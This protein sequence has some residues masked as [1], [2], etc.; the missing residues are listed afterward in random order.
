MHLLTVPRQDVTGHSQNWR[1][2]QDSIPRI[3]IKKAS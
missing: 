3:E 2:A 1:A